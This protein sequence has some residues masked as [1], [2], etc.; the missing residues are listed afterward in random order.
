[1]L[2]VVAEAGPGVEDEALGAVFAVLAEFVV[3]EDA[4]GFVDAAGATDVFGVEDVAHIFGVESVEVADDGIELCLEDGAAV[5]VEDEGLLFSELREFQLLFVCQFVK[6][7]LGPAI[8]VVVEVCEFSHSTGYF[9]LEVHGDLVERNNRELLDEEGA[10]VGSSNLL[11][12]HIIERQRR[13]CCQHLPR[14]G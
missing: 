3:F 4:E 1:M 14:Q 6:Q 9:P 2:S 10:H 5:G 7:F 11:P 12:Y 8:K 13:C